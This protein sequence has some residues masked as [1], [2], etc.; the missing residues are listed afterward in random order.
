MGR[1]LLNDRMKRIQVLLSDEEH[2]CFKQYCEGAGVSMSAALREW[3]LATLADPASESQPRLFPEHTI[4]LPLMAEEHR[5]FTDYCTAV[6][7]P[8]A[9]MLQKWVR[10]FLRHMDKEASSYRP[11]DLFNAGS[12]E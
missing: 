9:G 4:S 1:A 2:H 6:G 11:R 12:G 10:D 5:R 7:K 3:A 8:H